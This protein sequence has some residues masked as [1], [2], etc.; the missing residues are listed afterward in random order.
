MTR[1]RT[2]LILAEAANPEWVSVPLIGW[3]LSTAIARACDAHIVTQ[4]RNREAFNRAGM[5]EGRDYTAID[6]ENLARPMWKVA[7][8]LRGGKGLGWTIQ[9]AISSITYPYF[10]RLV[11]RKFGDQIRARKFDVVHRITP[12]TPTAP[13]S[14]AAKCR[15]VGTPF[16][17][18]PL[19]G[20]VPW[21]PGYDATRRQER[22]W[23]SYVRSVYKLMPGRHRTLA[24]AA[25]LLMGSRHTM[26][27]VPVKYQSKCIYMPE[28][29][30]EPSRFNRVA[31]PVRDGV[32]RA[33]FVGRL[34]PYKG[35]DVALEAALPLLKAGRMRLDI[36][37]DGPLMP[38]LREIVA[39]EGVADSVVLHGWVS[40]DRVQDVMSA[41]HLLTFPSVREFGG[42][43]V[44]EAMAL[45]VVPVIV[46][47]AGPGELVDAAVG[48]KV[49]IGLRADIVRAY[50]EM[51]IDLSTDPE[52][53]AEL[54]SNARQRV[55]DKFTWDAK[56]AQVLTAYEW[57]CNSGAKPEFT[58]SAQSAPI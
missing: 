19:N 53:L 2:A 16:L 6:T 30:I 51:L 1:K 36:V 10:E 34:V 13:S 20:G 3:S 33:C 44:L 11:W 37:G 32:L 7:T 57:V 55:L 22:E 23:L 31:S 12:L 9:T 18:G 54:G 8:F 21:P 14:L 24:S 58:F 39:R 38:M 35:P 15:A 45:G 28:N 49:P 26:S 46:D 43:V 40:H 48:F 52:R 17:L 25:A 41:C 4:V 56:A 29:A 50:A 27:E 47:Y 5:V 42:G